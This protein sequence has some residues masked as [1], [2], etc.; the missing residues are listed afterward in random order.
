[1]VIQLRDKID[2][3]E[4]ALHDRLVSYLGAYP[5]N[6]KILAL[7][8]LQTLEKWLSQA[9]E[10]TMLLLWALMMRSYN[11]LYLISLILSKVVA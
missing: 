7:V 10:L 3:K 11:V 6:K 9:G 4:I 8:S 5:A 2:K 1:V